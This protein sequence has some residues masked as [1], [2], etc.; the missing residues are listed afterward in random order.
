MRSGAATS[1]PVLESGQQLALGTSPGTPFFPPIIP[2]PLPWAGGSYT[3]AVHVASPKHWLQQS[4][5]D[6]ATAPLG[7]AAEREGL[8]ASVLAAPF[9]HWRGGAGPE[10]LTGTH[11][12]LP[13]RM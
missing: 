9:V 6:D 12:S 2:L 8:A 11:Q 13:S 10:L 7:K 3:H 5:A 1:P 4:P